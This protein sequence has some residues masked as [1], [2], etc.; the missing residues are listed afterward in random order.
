VRGCSAPKAGLSVFF[1]QR[2]V[3]GTLGEGVVALVE[4]GI[5]EGIG[6]CGIA[7]VDG[8]VHDRF[9]DMTA[10]LA[11]ALDGLRAAER[12]DLRVH[13]RAWMSARK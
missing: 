12:P 9:R 10:W 3:Q 11:A 13:H 8:R 5:A 6:V 2:P 4:G 1:L 7:E